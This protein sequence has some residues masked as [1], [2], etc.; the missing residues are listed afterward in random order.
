MGSFQAFYVFPEAQTPE[1][2]SYLLGGAHEAIGQL[3]GAQTVVYHDRAHA[4]IATYWRLQIPTTRL[5]GEHFRPQCAPSA[6]ANEPSVIPAPP[7]SLTRFPRYSLIYYCR[8]F[9]VHSS[10]D[11][12]SYVHGTGLSRTLLDKQQ[13]V[14][15]D[16]SIT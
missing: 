1:A 13:R 8:A 5:R 7:C 10:V 2:G 3:G 14:R 16:V 12:H 15:H 11:G 9:T 4:W 6:K